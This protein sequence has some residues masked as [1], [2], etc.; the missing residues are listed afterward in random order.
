M[1]SYKTFQYRIK[2]SSIAEKLSEKACAVN[3][4]FNY[5]NELQKE[6]LEGEGKKWLSHFDLCKLTSG[7]SKLL[8]ISS[9]SIQEVCK[10]YATRR[11]QF[12]KP[13]LKFRSNKKSLPWIPF[14]ARGF[15]FNRETGRTKYAGLEFG[16]WYSRPSE[17]IIKTGSICA[18]S[19]G[20][21]YLNVVCELPEVEAPA[22]D[23][24]NSVGI[25]LGLKDLATLSN[26]RKIAAQKYYRKQER[27][28][29]EAQRNGKKRT[30]RKL[31]A[32]VKN[33]RKDFNHKLSHSLVEEFDVIIVGDVSSTDIVN[34]PKTNMAKSVYDVSWYQL[35]SFISYKALAKKKTYLE[36]SERYSTQI[37][38]AC[39]CISDSSP[40]GVNGLSIR[41]WTCAECHETH[42][43]D[44]NAAKNI[45]RFGH[46]SLLNRN[47][48]S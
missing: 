10:E 21:Y 8:G 15:S 28:I 34:S 23:I 43:R 42:D 26:G 41:M 7:L 29:A 40:K 16:L 47:L 45:L 9:T 37:C 22:L 33:Q 4:I 11:A 31:H 3:R 6:A 35:K 12:K 19:R 39:G 27:R 36:V 38:S 30:V 32:K 1:K 44:I 48:G 17:G 18:D 13:Y 24:N 5:C 20:R 46:E 14:N 25:D 2:D